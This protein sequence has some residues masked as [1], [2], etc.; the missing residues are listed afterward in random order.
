MKIT[1][2]RTQRFMSAMGNLLGMIK[3]SGEAC[4]EKYSGMGAKEFSIINY[5]GTFHDVKMKD[6]ADHMNAPIS[7]LTSIVDKLVDGNYLTRYHSSEDRRVVLVTLANNGKAVF[8]ECL[9]KMSEFATIVLSKY[10]EADQD[11]YIKFL[12][13]MSRSEEEMVDRK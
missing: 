5:V 9:T 3:S 6:I 4:C 10:G 8:N 12:E 13:D 2:D 1:T 7:T 11:K